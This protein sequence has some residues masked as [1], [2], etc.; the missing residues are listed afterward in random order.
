MAERPKDTI[1]TTTTVTR[2]KMKFESGLYNEKKIQIGAPEPSPY[3]P[4]VTVDVEPAD[5]KET[6]Y[7]RKI[8][9]VQD[10]GYE[11]E[12]DPGVRTPLKEFRLVLGPPPEPNKS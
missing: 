8:V 10:D 3:E 6:M 7:I 11:V 12:I 4:V 2:I 9:L 5:Q 1:L